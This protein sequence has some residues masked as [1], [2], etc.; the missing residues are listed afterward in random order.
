MEKL[1][2]PG[3]IPI[4]SELLAQCEFDIVMDLAS[5]PAHYELNKKALEA[6][7]HLYSQ[8]PVALN[9]EQ[10]ADLIETA[11]RNGVKFSASPS[12]CSVRISGRPDS[13]L[14]TGRSAGFCS[15]RSMVAHGGPEYFQ[16]RANDPS[17]FY[18]PGAG[19]LY[20]LGCM[21]CTW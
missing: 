19:A 12:I 5:I 3:D 10:A 21:P 9:E 4:L 18:E 11:R 15:I 14:P 16:Y 7:K 1:G 17:W 2:F 20:D 13:C 8:K 6:G